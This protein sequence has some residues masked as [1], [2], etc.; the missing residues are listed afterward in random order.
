VCS[1]DLK[2]KVGSIVLLNV[3]E[4]SVNRCKRLELQIEM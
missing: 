3:I 4:T 2:I 1:S